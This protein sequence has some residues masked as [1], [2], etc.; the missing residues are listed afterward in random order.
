MT[1][2]IVDH[3]GKATSISADTLLTTTNR[4]GIERDGNTNAIVPGALKLFILS[5][6]LCL[7]FAGANLVAIKLL[8]EIF[9]EG[10][11][12]DLEPLKRAI[13]K[14]H[15]SS[16]K[17][18]HKAT[19][20]LLCL[21][22]QKLSPI[23]RNGGYLE[24]HDNCHIGNSHAYNSID[25]DSADRRS[26]QDLTDHSD[27][28]TV[29]GLVLSVSDNGKYFHYSYSVNF[30]AQN[31]EEADASFGFQWVTIAA[32]VPF[33]RLGIYFIG[34]EFGCLYD[35]LNHYETIVIEAQS[36][37]IF[38]EVAALHNACHIDIGTELITAGDSIPM[39]FHCPN[40]NSS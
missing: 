28:P 16:I 10:I 39:I 7:C 34:G 9:Q 4:K 35:P 15:N 38:K 14:T 12:N 18:K 11:Q 13:S 2:A 6:D 32:N 24:T 23:W 21:R 33:P 29:G 20:F 19:D 3:T 25:A 31:T 17:N 22:K 8:R 26:I 30:S 1:L 5:A 27:F 37:E 36:I 40:G